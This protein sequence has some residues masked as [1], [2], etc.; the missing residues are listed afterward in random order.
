[1]LSRGVDSFWVSWVKGYNDARFFDEDGDVREAARG[2]H[3]ADALATEARLSL[4][5]S[6]LMALA[7]CASAR[8]AGYMNCMTPI[9]NIIVRVHLAYKAQLDMLPYICSGAANTKNAPKMMLFDPPAFTT[10]TIVLM[11]RTHGLSRQTLTL[12]SWL[13]SRGSCLS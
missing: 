9:H 6:Q 11:L 13:Q 5:S 2:N 4:Y 1:M 3:R 10:G 7:D 12:T 8:T